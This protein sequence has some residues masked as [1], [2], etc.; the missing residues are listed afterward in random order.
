MRAEMKEWVEDLKSTV[1][2]QGQQV[3][4]RVAALEARV[5]VP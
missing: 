1:L 5:E 2:E 4:A 3:N